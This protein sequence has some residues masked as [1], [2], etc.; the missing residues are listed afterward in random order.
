MSALSTL[1]Q[2]DTSTPE[3]TKQSLARLVQELDTLFEAIAKEPK[4]FTGFGSPEDVLA[5]PVGSLYLR[6]DGSTSTTLY[7]K[8]GGSTSRTGWVAK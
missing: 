4:A 5:A 7:V 6:S 3:A 2:L 8:E 1:R